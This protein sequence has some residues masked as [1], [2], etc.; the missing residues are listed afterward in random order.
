M[1]RGCKGVLDKT[2]LGS[3]VKLGFLVRKVFAVIRNEFSSVVSLV[4]RSI[5]GL[6]RDYLQVTLLPITKL[7]VTSFHYHASHLFPC[8]VIN[9]SSQYHA[10]L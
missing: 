2:F 6:V 8:S 7:V 1:Q 4:G 9:H 3:G 5:D 10:N